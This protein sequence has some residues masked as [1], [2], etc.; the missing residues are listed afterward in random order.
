[1]GGL[2]RDFTQKDRPGAAEADAM[3]FARSRAGNGGTNSTVLGKRP[4]EGAEEAE[5][6]DEEVGSP[7]WPDSPPSTR[8][9]DGER[10]RDR[11]PSRSPGL[12]PEL[13]AVDDEADAPQ[14][15]VWRDPLDEDEDDAPT[16]KRARTET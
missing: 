3:T 10:G 4:A 1:M 2:K 14:A 8:N 15:E 11:A 7:D 16:A 5:Q 6:Q 13:Q 9:V 12:S